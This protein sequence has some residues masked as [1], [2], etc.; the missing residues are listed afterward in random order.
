MNTY[1]LFMIDE[2]GIKKEVETKKEIKGIKVLNEY[3]NFFENA[4][5]TKKR[6]V[7]FIFEDESKN[8]VYIED[9]KVV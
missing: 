7:T 1:K 9:R 6:N 4:K 3:I 2:K 8:M 5:K